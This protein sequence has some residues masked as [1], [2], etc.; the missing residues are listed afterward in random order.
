MAGSYWNKSCTAHGRWLSRNEEGN[1]RFRCV[2]AL[3]LTIQIG[4]AQLLQQLLP[5]GERNKGTCDELIVF[6]NWHHELTVRIMTMLFGRQ[7]VMRMLGLS[8]RIMSTRSAKKNASSHFRRD[9]KIPVSFEADIC[10]CNNSHCQST[11]L[12]NSN[13]D[14]ILQDIRFNFRLFVNGIMLFKNSSPVSRNESLYFK[15][16]SSQARIAKS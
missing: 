15:K 16:K 10:S 2:R 5:L 7:I 6:F 14:L 4:G 8:N 11:W 9:I 3:S 12:H 13:I 1:F